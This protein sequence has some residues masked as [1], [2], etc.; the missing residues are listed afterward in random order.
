M[1]RVDEKFSNRGKNPWGEYSKDGK[2]RKGKDWRN[3]RRDKQKIRDSSIDN[4]GK[5]F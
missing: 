3:K 2:K 1:G 5:D 4:M